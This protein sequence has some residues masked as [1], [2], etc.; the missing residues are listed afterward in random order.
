MA[1]KEAESSLMLLHCLGLA[2]LPW[3]LD[4][5]G[6]SSDSSTAL[7][8]ATTAISALDQLAACAMRKT[9]LKIVVLEYGRNVRS[10]ET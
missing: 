7:T 1:P 3:Q 4:E 8:A 2:D 10:Q 5:T 6:S 9:T